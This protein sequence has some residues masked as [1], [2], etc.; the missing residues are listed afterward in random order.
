[1]PTITIKL[2]PKIDHGNTAELVAAL[3][4]GRAHS[5]E[6]RVDLYEVTSY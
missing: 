2:P 6:V 4:P 1:M 3:A 5:G